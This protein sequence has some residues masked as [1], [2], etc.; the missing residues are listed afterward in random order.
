MLKSQHGTAEKKLASEKRLW[1]SIIPEFNAHALR[2]FLDFLQASGEMRNSQVGILH[3]P[4]VSY[5]G[6]M[7]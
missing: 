6:S 3:Y 7:I 2:N 1:H 5:A 4:A